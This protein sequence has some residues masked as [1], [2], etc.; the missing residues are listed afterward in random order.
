MYSLK[1]CS[2]IIK[3]KKKKLGSSKLIEKLN[4]SRILNK[5]IICYKIQKISIYPIRVFV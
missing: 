3:I 5:I 1:V 4:N 2:Y